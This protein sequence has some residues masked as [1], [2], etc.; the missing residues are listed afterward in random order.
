MT[1]ASNPTIDKRY[2]GRDLGDEYLIYDDAG[3]R[4][5]VLNAT[6]REIYLLCDGDRSEGE[7]ARELMSRYDVSEDVAL[8]DIR[9]TLDDLI[10]RGLVSRS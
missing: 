10:E 5:H 8:R 4:V 9:E 6:A 1:A 3:D 7:M 2:P